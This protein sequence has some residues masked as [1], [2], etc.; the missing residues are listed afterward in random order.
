MH[1]FHVLNNHP[2]LWLGLLV[3]IYGVAVALDGLSGRLGIG[4]AEKARKHPPAAIVMGLAGSAF[5]WLSI[6]PMLSRRS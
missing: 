6:W 4:D 5:F 3:S 2:V 1:F